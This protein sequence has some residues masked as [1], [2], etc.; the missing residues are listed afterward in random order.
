MGKVLVNYFEQNFVLPSQLTD[1]I[2]ARLLELGEPSEKEAENTVRT[3]L[4]GRRTDQ[5]KM[6][7]VGDLLHAVD[8]YLAKNLSFQATCYRR[9]YC[10]RV[11]F[12]CILH[13]EA[14]LDIIQ[15]T[16][17]FRAENTADEKKAFLDGH[18]SQIIREYK[19]VTGK[20]PVNVTCNLLVIVHWKY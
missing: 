7:L 15:C 18:E 2:V 4:Q 12:L 19:R 1:A 14:D 16:A 10:D 9:E 11:A 3:Y 6:A 5:G 13:E 17:P 20:R 8:K